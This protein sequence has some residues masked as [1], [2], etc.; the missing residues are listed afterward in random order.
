MRTGSGNMNTK[1]KLLKLF[2]E[3]RGTYFSGEAIAEILSISRAG[4]WKAVNRLREEGYEIDA[5]TNKGYCLAANSDY[6]SAAVIRKHLDPSLQ[7]MELHL[8]SETASTNDAM[9]DLMNSGAPEGTVIIA[10]RQSGGKGRSG[11][12]FFS[13][14]DSGIYLSLLLRPAGMAPEKAVRLTTIAAVAACEA[15]ELISGRDAAIKW[16]ND[17]YM[18]GKKVCGILTEGSVSMENGLVDSV[19]LGIGINVSPPEGGFPEELRETAGTV[20]PERVCN[21]R[22]ILTAGFLNRFMGYYL[23][24]DSQAYTS[25]YRARCFVPGKDVTVIGPQGS[26]NARALDVDDECRLVVRYE[27]GEIG[28]L[29]SGEIR[30]RLS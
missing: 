18:D 15:I 6:L 2:E 25:R 14:P 19:I 1:E 26:R 5:V 23:S 30:V 4:V 20:F 11:R 3:H 12:N 10:G 13:P 28:R 21:A 7:K 16:V 8:L 29:S 22:N 24:G 17:I 9:R 27:D